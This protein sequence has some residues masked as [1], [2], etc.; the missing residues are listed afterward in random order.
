MAGPC[1][2]CGGA[3]SLRWPEQNFWRCGTCSLLV[4]DATTFAAP[5]PKLYE[6]S[7]KD[8]MAHADE[9]GGM[10]PELAALYASRLA[11]S[12]GLADFKGLRLMDFGAGTGDFVVALQSAGAHV[13]AVDAYGRDYLRSKGIPAF[14]DL[15]ELPRDTAFDGIVTSDV[16]EHLTAPWVD[17]AKFRDLLKPGGWL[18][19]STP[20][21]SSLNARLT[22][23]R[24]REAQKPGHIIFFT[25]GAMERALQK[26]GFE[27]RQRLRWHL[28]Y[29]SNP[30]RNGV[31]RIL[32]WLSL[33]GAMRYIAWK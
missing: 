26:A 7:W 8:P 19:V 31:Q 2:L 6:G 11:G 17:M 4:R 9:T 3:M 23:G 16:V 14:G 15:S 32:Q 30:L 20:N 1:G 24:W 22:K 21:P 13:T 5:L 33:D 28:G 29:G 18:Y 27:R 25:G 12:L 10:T